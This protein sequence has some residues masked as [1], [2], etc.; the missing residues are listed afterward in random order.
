MRAARARILGVR[1]LDGRQHAADEHFRTRFETRQ[2]LAR[3]RAIGSQ[4]R[5]VLRERMAREIE[6]EDFL[7]HHE[8]F[9]FGKLGHVRQHGAC[10]CGSIVAIAVK[11][12]ALAALAIRQHGRAALH[13][14]IDRR[15]QLRTLRAENIERA[16]LDERFDGRPTAGLRIDPLAK[17]EQARKIAIQ[18]PRRAIASA[19]PLPQPLIALRPNRI[20]LPAT[21]KSTSDRFTFGGTT[22]TFIRSAVFQVLD[23]RVLA[24]EIAALECRPRAARP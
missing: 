19:A 22:V 4:R 5:F 23:Q 16:G 24:L 20:S 14:P 15:H 8:L 10:R 21:A 3:V 7:L 12:A 13:R 6:A 17:V 9:F 2:L 18:S 11:Q 1:K